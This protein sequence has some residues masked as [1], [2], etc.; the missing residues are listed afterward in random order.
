MART[1][2]DQLLEPSCSGTAGGNA[3]VKDAPDLCLSCKACKHGR[4]VKVD[5]AADKAEFL[6]HCEESHR[7]PLSAP[8]FGFIDRWSQR[9]NTVP[10][11]AN[12]L[13]SREP[14]AGLPLRQVARKALVQIHCHHKA[15][16][17]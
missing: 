3:A 17:A 1:T 9:V 14:S 2:S 6:S 8:L 15:V 16:L 7:R 4:G 11:L 12:W 10:G 13:T 5:M